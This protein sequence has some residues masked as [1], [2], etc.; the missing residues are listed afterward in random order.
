ML[1]MIITSPS[2]SVGITWQSHCRTLCFPTFDFPSWLVFFCYILFYSFS[3]LFYESTK[4]DDNPSNL[5]KHTF[6][7]T[8][9]QNIFY[10]K[11]TVD[12]SGFF[13]KNTRKVHKAYLMENISKR[14][15]TMSMNDIYIIGIFIHKT[16]S[17]IT[18]QCK[19]NRSSAE[20]NKLL[21]DPIY[22]CGTVRACK[23]LIGEEEKL[24]CIM[25]LNEHNGDGIIV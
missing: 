13:T 21:Y 12:K 4:I 19:G 1:S 16:E 20:F 14:K 15:G 7:G 24:H 5:R 8:F 3:L 17:L 9:S 2:C 10:C 11:F 23:E 6:F 25:L 18:K 22:N